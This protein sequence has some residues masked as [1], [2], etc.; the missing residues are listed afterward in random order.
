MTAFDIEPLQHLKIQAAFQ[1]YTDNAVSKTINLPEEATVEDVKEI[2]I[3]AHE[4]KCKGITTYRYGSKD[5]QVLS[6]GVRQK[7]I[8]ETGR[9]FVV[10]E[11]EYTGGC[12]AGSCIF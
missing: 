6:F 5:W 7:D 10:A 8:S 11:S 4:L 12:A 2:Y 3:K 1:K 9:D